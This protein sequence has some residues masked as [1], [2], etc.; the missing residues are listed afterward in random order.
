MHNDFA[1]LPGWFKMMFAIVMLTCVGIICICMVDQPR[2]QTEIAELKTSIET[3]VQREVKQQAEYDAVAAKLPAAQEELAALQ[4]V[5]DAA[6]AE[7]DELR[8]T[9]DSLRDEQTVK[10]A[11]LDML[12]TG[13]TN[14]KNA[15]DVL[16]DEE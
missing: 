1:R 7:A 2:L 3:S 11:E 5:A 12:E 13:I 9:R 4:P 14:L 8:T 10:T 6:K 15:L 16:S